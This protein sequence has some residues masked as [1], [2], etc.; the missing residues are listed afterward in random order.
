MDARISRRRFVDRALRASAVGLAAP[1]VVPSHAL[2]AGGASDRI[3]VGY[4][5][6]GA[7]GN[8]ILRHLTESEEIV[9]LCDVN[10]RYLAHHA[11]AHPK[12]ATCAD[13]RKLLDS[14]DV[15]AV[16]ITTPDHWHALQSIHAC[17]AGKDVYCDKPLSLTVREGRAMVDAARRHERV[18]QVG[19]Q[20]R[21]IPASRHACEFVRSG[22]LGKIRE[23][24]CTNNRTSRALDLSA[25]PAPDWLDWDLWLG[26]SPKRPFHPDLVPSRKGTRG[27]MA[28]KDWS[29]GMMTSWGTHGLDIAQ[30]GLGMD[31]SGPAEVEPL[32]KGLACPLQYR[33]ANGIVLKLDRAPQG[34][35]VF[36]GEKGTVTAYTGIVKWDPPELGKGA[37]PSSKRFYRGPMHTRQW[38]KSIR[39]RQ[40]PTCDVEVGHR[41]ATIAHIGNIARWLGRRLRWDPAKETFPGDA[42]ADAMLSRPQRPPWRL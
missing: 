28:Y 36:V 23:V 22:K 18:F 29:G 5:G 38:L 30:W 21:S 16:I 14:K 35:A 37:P 6:L 40:R 27:W 17:Q 41:A 32:G 12:S 7:R 13:Y 15:D 24:H 11:K 34:G 20:Q 33:Y 3:G 39:A 4:I 31:G 10:Q 26:P 8:Q 19:P 9:A 25:V 42:E 1:Y 2:A